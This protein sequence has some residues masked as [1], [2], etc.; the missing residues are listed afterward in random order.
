MPNVLRPSRATVYLIAA[1]IIQ[2][3]FQYEWNYEAMLLLMDIIANDPRTPN[4]HKIKFGNAIDG[5]NNTKNRFQE[6]GVQGTW[7]KQQAKQAV[8]CSLMKFDDDG[9][10][11]HRSNQL[12]NNLLPHKD[13]NSRDEWKHKCVT[14]LKD[15]QSGDGDTIFSKYDNITRDSY[16]Y[17]CISIHLCYFY[18]KIV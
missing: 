8:A 15:Y 4:P 14:Y 16:E 3:I 7:Y 11:H 6:I 17:I 10:L 12:L 1:P 9:N 13:R 18:I 5:I 2:Y